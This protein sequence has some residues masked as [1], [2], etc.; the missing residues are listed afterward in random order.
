MNYNQDTPE[1]LFFYDIKSETDSWYW[2]STPSNLLN[3][4]RI[5]LLI[6][7]GDAYAQRKDG[8]RQRPALII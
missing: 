5:K 1:N 8:F 3:A 2:F 7:E 6:T 4:A